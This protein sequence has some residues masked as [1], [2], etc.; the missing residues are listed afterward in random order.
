MSCNFYRTLLDVGTN[1]L[2][3]WT[4]VSIANLLLRHLDPTK[5]SQNVGIR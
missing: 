2:M 5:S 1:F 4:C 3:V